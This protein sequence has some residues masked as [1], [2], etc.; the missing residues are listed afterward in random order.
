MNY[1]NRIIDLNES[2]KIQRKR[3]RVINNVQARLMLLPYLHI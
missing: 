2:L 3:V 1:E